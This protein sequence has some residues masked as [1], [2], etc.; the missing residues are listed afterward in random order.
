MK[1]KLVIVEQKLEV[2]LIAL[3]KLGGGGGKIITIF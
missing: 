3:S 2:F 1:L